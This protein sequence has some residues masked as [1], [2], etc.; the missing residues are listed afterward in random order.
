MSNENERFEYTYSPKRQEEIEAIRRKYLPL[1][2]DNMIKLKRLDEK[3]ERPGTIC[4]IILGLC[5]ILF[6]GSGMSLALVWTETQLITGV[7]FGFV[8]F[9][10]MGAAYPVYKK[11]TEK[12]KEK[13]REEILQ[14]SEELLKYK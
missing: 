13:Y 11:I 6:F 8:G 4:A 1:E 3:V 5:G 7:V 14:L 9:V 10:V 2:E 12:Q